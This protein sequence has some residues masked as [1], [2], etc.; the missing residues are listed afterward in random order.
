MGSN[1]SKNI[2]SDENVPIHCGEWGTEG[3]RYKRSIIGGTSA[4]SPCM[5]GDI[6]SYDTK[7][8]IVVKQSNWCTVMCYLIPEND[9]YSIKLPTI[10]DVNLTANVSLPVAWTI[11][12]VRCT[13]KMTW[14]Q[15][16]KWLTDTWTNRGF[17]ERHKLARS[18]SNARMNP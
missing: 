4:K 7:L 15:Y 12:I 5:M 9:D 14:V 13:G 6:V 3:P 17:H 2:Y 10:S 11:P 8:Y 16:I 1:K 18:R